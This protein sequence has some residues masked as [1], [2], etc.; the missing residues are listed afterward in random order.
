MI[1]KSGRDETHPTSL[2]DK[3]SNGTV[4]RG[5]KNSLDSFKL[6]ICQKNSSEA[7]QNAAAGKQAEAEKSIIIY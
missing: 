7:K 5:R 2:I 3:I 4:E 1:K 6:L